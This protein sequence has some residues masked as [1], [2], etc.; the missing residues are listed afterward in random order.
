MQW[1]TLCTF[2]D[3]ERYTLSAWPLL[4]AVPA[5]KVGIFF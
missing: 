4:F 3:A 1:T 5:I 2:T